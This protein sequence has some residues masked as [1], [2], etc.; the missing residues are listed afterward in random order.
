MCNDK[1]LG[2]PVPCP[3]CGRQIPAAWRKCS[4][5][6]GYEPKLN[7]IIADKPHLAELIKKWIKIFG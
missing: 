1:K 5:C 3:E 6:M 4:W 2:G 7:D